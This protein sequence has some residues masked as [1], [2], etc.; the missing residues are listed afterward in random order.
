MR[1]GSLIIESLVALLIIA[2]SVGIAYVPTGNLLKKSLENRYLIELSNILLNEAETLTYMNASSI[3]SETFKK[4]YNNR[5]YTI[6]I[7]KK[8]ENLKDKITMV[9]NEKGIIFSD[10]IVV[11]VR[12]VAPDGK[13]IETQ[14]VPQQ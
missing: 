14:V 10:I 13:Y 7:I 6:Q 2:M 5:E 11:T 4:I 12:V 9:S 8:T 3:S 1:K